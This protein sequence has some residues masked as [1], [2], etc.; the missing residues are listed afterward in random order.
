MLLMWLRNWLAHNP[1]VVLAI[2]GACLTLLGGI[3]GAF[4]MRLLGRSWLSGSEAAR[5]YIRDLQARVKFLE[6]KVHKRNEIIKSLRAI[7]SGVDTEE[8]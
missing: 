2:V 3:L 5:E 7:L 4:L 1:F 8:E 6:E